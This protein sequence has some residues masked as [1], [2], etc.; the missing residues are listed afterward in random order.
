MDILQNNQ[1]NLA[2]AIK[3]AQIRRCTLKSIKESHVR[4]TLFGYVW[5]YHQPHNLNQA[6]DDILHLNVNEIIAYL[7]NQAVILGA[8]LDVDDIDDLL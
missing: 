2:I 6:V 7:S 5:K 3:T 4:A 8:Q 1:I